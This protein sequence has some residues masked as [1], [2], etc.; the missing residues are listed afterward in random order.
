MYNVVSEM[1][2]YVKWFIFAGLWKY[3]LRL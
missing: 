2:F 3:I 1:Y